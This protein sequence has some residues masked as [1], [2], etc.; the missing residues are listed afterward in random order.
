MNYKVTNLLKIDLQCTNCGKYNTFYKSTGSFTGKFEFVSSYECPNCKNG[1]MLS[2]RISTGRP[3]IKISLP[4]PFHHLSASVL[5][6]V[7]ENYPK[8]DAEIEKSSFNSLLVDLG[9]VAE[10]E[11]KERLSESLNKMILEEMANNMSFTVI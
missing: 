5:R 3:T 1:D 7:K 8:Y 11:D 4:H 10:G 6:Y 9:D 2:I